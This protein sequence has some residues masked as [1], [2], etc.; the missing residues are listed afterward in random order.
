MNK[1]EAIKVQLPD[2]I[3][4]AN[5]SSTDVEALVER[6]RYDLKRKELIAKHKEQIN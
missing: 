3:D 2:E 6:V 1:M 5:L 4:Y